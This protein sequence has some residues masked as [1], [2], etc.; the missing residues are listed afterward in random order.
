M[1]ARKLSALYG[2]KWNPFLEDIP[3]EALCKTPR[4]EHFAWRVEDLVTHG[5]F[6]LVTGDVGAGKSSA[7]RL[8]VRAAR[9]AAR[10][11]SSGKL[12]RPQSRV[13]DFYREIGDLFG[14]AVS[15]SNRWGALQGRAREVAGAHPADAVSPGAPHRRGPG[16]VAAPCSPSCASSA[17]P[18][19]THA[20]SSPSSCAGDRRLE[21]HLR[22]PTSCRSTAASARGSCSTPSLRRCSARCCATSSRPRATPR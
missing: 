20:R 17:R 1:D 15:T 14:V 19:S 8:L 13:T 22:T 18:S 5:G 10:R 9:A 12:E 2:L 16:D 4:I 7:L 3:V 21:E 11:S 6:A